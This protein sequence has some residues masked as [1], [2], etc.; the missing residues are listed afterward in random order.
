[1]GN[2]THVLRFKYKPVKT[3]DPK[4]SGIVYWG[5]DTF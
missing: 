5:V 1:M 2:T 4:C 3:P